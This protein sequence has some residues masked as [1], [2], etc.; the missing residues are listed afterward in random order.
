M[1]TSGLALLLCITAPIASCAITCHHLSDRAVT[2][3]N[4]AY[5]DVVRTG[6]A[7]SREPTGTA[8]GSLTSEAR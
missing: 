8:G 1:K 7:V 3:S 2:G 4:Y 5:P 6:N